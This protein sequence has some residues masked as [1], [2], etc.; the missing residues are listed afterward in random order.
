MAIGVNDILR[1][2][3]QW[4]AD[5]SDEIVNVHHFRVD[6]LGTTTGDG[7]FML[8]LVATLAAELYDQVLAAIANNI[9]GAAVTGFNV[10]KNE[11]LPP[12]T[13]TI[14]GASSASDALPRQTSALVYLNTTVARRQGRSY[15]PPFA[16]V[17]MDDDGTWSTDTITVLTDYATKLINPITDGDITVLRMVTTP[18]GGSAIA[19]SYAG[20]S[21]YPRTQRRRT[22]GFG[23]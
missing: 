14:D 16:E 11:T 15:L 23:S 7:D 21:L 17:A 6:D 20:F 4:F 13:N 19:P 12:Q 22:P 2:A 9:V 18:S 10:T 3:L 8:Q 5:G 1:V